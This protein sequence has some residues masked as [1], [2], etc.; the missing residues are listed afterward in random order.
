MF[1]KLLSVIFFI[2][3]AVGAQASNLVPLSTLEDM[4]GVAPA[5]RLAQIELVA[6]EGALQA[7]TAAAA[8]RLFG[9]GS[10]SY[11][12]ESALPETYRVQ[13]TLPSGVSSYMD[14]VLTPVPS[15]RTRINALIGV[16]FALFGRRDQLAR[17]IDASAAG[18]EAQ[19]LRIDVA[20]LEVVKALRNAYV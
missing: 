14:E 12:R 7:A 9:M 8:P 20:R 15:D 19:R 2:A 4:V 10:L 3:Q 6:A 13:Q 5:V 17:D 16:R 1:K 11:G 18:V